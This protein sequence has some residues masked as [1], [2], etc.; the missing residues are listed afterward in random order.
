MRCGS[1]NTSNVVCLLLLLNV[2][3]QTGNGEEDKAHMAIIWNM[4]IHKNGAK[5]CGGKI[6]A[7]A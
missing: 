3:T 4:Q 2:L 5:I 7:Y 6:E 1:R